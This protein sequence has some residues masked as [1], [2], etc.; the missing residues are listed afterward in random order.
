MYNSMRKKRG[1]CPFFFFEENKKGDRNLRYYISDLHF[2]HK[3]LNDKM[4]VRG[5]DDVEEM[6]EY[7]INQWN[8]K[9][10]KRDEVVVL[11]DFSWGNAKETTEV[12]QRLNGKIFLI[13][14]NHDRFLDEKSFD[15]SM[16][17][18]VRDYA[19]L[20]DNRRKVVLSHYPIAFYNGQYR[21]DELGRPKTYMLHGHIHNTQ[22]R[23]DLDA[24]IDFMA[25]RKHIS[26]G[27]ELENVPCQIINCFCQD[28]DYEPLTLDEWIELDEKR[29][30]RRRKTK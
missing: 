17:G 16:F 3:A 13:R 15:V 19:E 25:T 27:N 2:F 9:V 30:I 14:G 21:K 29:K 24:F 20:N 18:W 4:D 7:M 23:D 6:N 12:I 1:I 28:S 8:R 5:F 10:K 22:D 11:G 26:I